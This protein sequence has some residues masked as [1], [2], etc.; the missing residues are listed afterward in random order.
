MILA[1]VRSSDFVEFQI[2]AHGLVNIAVPRRHGYLISAAIR[3]CS[4]GRD[5]IFRSGY[6]EVVRLSCQAGKYECNPLVIVLPIF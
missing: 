6:S 4:S 2:E 5:Y 3:L 1:L